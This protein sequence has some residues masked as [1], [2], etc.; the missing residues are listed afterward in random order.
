[1][2]EIYPEQITSPLP[3]N[4]IILRNPVSSRAPQALHKI[5]CLEPYFSELDRID[6][7]DGSRETNKQAL[8]E[9]LLLKSDDWLENACVVVVGGDGTVDM[10]AEG[11]YEAPGFI[12]DMPI[13]PIGAG[14]TN[15]IARMIHG[16][17]GAKHPERYINRPKV[18]AIRPLECIFENDKDAQAI[19]GLGYATVGL[20]AR[21]AKAINNSRV[22]LEK[23]TK[24]N[25]RLRP[26]RLAR[27]VLDTCWS[28]RLF[29]APDMESGEPQTYVDIMAI[30][31]SQMAGSVRTPANLEDTGFFLTTANSCRMSSI[32]AT[33]A[34]LAMGRA[35]GEIRHTPYELETLR[36]NTLQVGGETW[37]LPPN[38]SVA[39][40]PAERELA[41]ISLAP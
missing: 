17:L 13:L 29:T 24:L 38:T 35:P 8:V 1:M 32:L 39:I 18:V 19:I 25:D 30:N 21:A 15:D 23:R 26:L 4:A 41:F 34:R 36:T 3:P 2:L 31:G 9:R 11:I 5:S 33:S 20:S 37:D 22:P 6:T 27:A 14:H 12:S 7:I 40:Q 10:A 16:R 28:A